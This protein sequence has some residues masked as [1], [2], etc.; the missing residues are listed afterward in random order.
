[1]LYGL[2]KLT[3]LLSLMGALTA[4]AACDDTVRGMGNDAEDIGDEMEDATE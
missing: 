4:L 1:M 2:R 3:L